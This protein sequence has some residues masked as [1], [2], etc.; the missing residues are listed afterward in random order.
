MG[1]ARPVRHVVPA[2]LVLMAC[3]GCSSTPAPERADVKERTASIETAATTIM[4]AIGEA[5]GVTSY[6]SSGRARWLY[7]GSP[8]SPTGAEYVAEVSITGTSSVASTYEDSIIA[9]LGSQGWTIDSTTADVIEAHDDQIELT[10]RYEGGLLRLTVTAPCLD[11]SGDDVETLSD[12]P[13]ADLGLTATPLPG[14]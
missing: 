4:P 6:S 12:L 13:S 14:S 8:P 11:L 5:V 10:A 3:A 1:V 2:A 9:S 7:C